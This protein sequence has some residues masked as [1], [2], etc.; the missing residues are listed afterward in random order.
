MHEIA[1][2][3]QTAAEPSIEWFDT[4]IATLRAHELQ[5]IANTVNA[6]LLNYGLQ[7]RKHIDVNNALNFSNPTSPARLPYALPKFY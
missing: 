7:Y 3:K 4:L 5:L 1:K 6:H 2:P